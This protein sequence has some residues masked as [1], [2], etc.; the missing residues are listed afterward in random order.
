M[1]E[2]YK[3]I[4]RFAGVCYS[5]KPF[6]AYGKL[7]QPMYSLSVWNIVWTLI[8]GIDKTLDRPFPFDPSTYASIKSNYESLARLRLTP[9]QH[10]SMVG[11]DPEQAIP[12]LMLMS[13]SQLVK[14]KT[15]GEIRRRLVTRFPSL[16]VP[17]EGVTL[18]DFSKG[19]VI[20]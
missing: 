19:R 12:V 15:E 10:V 6:K 3:K 2:F 14:P 18:V 4:D 5:P 20:R 8:P 1:R 13:E 9:R 16:S 17:S 7:T 11:D